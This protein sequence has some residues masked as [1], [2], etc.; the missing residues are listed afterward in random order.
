MMEL[1]KL[2]GA[3]GPLSASAATSYAAAAISGV[4]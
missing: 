4:G 2:S 3:V 1:G